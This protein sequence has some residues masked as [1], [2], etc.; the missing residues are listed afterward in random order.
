M[1][2]EEQPAYLRALMHGNTV[3][4]RNK[5]A[6]TGIKVGQIYVVMGC[7]LCR[8]VKIGHTDYPDIPS[9]AKYY[10]ESITVRY[11][12]MRYLEQSWW[13]IKWDQPHPEQHRYAL[14]YF[15]PWD[16]QGILYGS[17]KGKRLKKFLGQLME[18][19]LKLRGYEHKT[20]RQSRA[21][22]AKACQQREQWNADVFKLF[23]SLAD[24]KRYPKL[25]PSPPRIKTKAPPTPWSSL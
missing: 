21:I 25:P 18:I 7:Y 2:P 15:F 5:M 20:D 11:V 9:I 16:R 23:N 8:V 14:C 3:A 10:A 4:N 19:G 17:D 22:Y 24:P 1:N 13:N 12:G 6:L